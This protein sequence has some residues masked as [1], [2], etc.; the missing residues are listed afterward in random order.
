MGQSAPLPTDS[1]A[2]QPTVNR[3]RI[4]EYSERL[5]IS[6]DLSVSADYEVIDTDDAKCVIL[7]LP[8]TSWNAET[9]GQSDNPNAI[10]SH[11]EARTL[12]EENGVALIIYGTNAIRSFYH[13]PLAPNGKQGHRIY[14][15]LE[16]P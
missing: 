13:A 4:G 12:S 6:L 10:L 3:V 14:I 7:K 8:N 11:F 5:R 9:F 16:R 2:S 15:D 1:R